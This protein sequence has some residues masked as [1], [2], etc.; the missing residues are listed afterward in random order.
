MPEIA[1]DQHKQ[2][3]SLLR[4][5]LSTYKDSE[6]LINLGAY[7]KG[8]NPKVDKAIDYHDPIINF[9]RQGIKEYSTFDNSLKKLKSMI[10]V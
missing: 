4:D 1:E 3:T 8:S 10:S 6:D 2:V 9:L 7:V 5:L